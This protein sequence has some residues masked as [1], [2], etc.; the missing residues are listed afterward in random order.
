MKINNPKSYIAL[1]KKSLAF[2]LVFV[3]GNIFSLQAQHNAEVQIKTV[4]DQLVTAYGSAKA[5]PELQFMKTNPKPTTP[6]LYVKPVIKVDLKLYTLCQ[7][8][9]KDSLN[10]LS[11]VISHE[12]AHY[13]YDHSFCTDF[14]FAMSKQNIG[15]AKQIKLINKNQKVIYETQADDKGLF[16]AAIAGY[17]PFEIQPKILDAI[18]KTYQLKEINEGY[19]SKMERKAISQN[20]LVKSQKL[21]FVFQEALKAKEQNEYDKALSLFET[22]NQ[23]FPSR[24]NYNNSGVIKTLQAL[25]FK[26]LAKEEFDYPKRFLYPLEIDNTSRLNQSGTRSD[27]DDKKQVQMITLLKSAQKDFEKAISLDANYTT[28]YVNLACVFDLLDNWEAAIGKIKELSLDKQTSVDVKRILAIAYYH[29]DNEKKA[30]AIWKELK[31]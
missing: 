25:N 29:T 19:P 18:Y 16:Y 15:F 30:E 9:G 20:A 23:D 14:A 26:V 7:T 6:A 8:F 11:V 22:V 21:Y 17:A 1:Q 5:A 27:S 12:L 2:L 10:A 31:I 13:Y 24:E 3:I 28:A 4:F